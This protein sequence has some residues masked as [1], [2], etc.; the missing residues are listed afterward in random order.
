M[1]VRTKLGCLRKTERINHNM[2]RQEF[3]C[4]SLNLDLPDEG[5]RD[6][7]SACPVCGSPLGLRLA[8]VP[9]AQV[10]LATVLLL[11][12]LLPLAVG[13][14]FTFFSV[15]AADYV[16]KNK[17]VEARSR[18]ELPEYGPDSV[19]TTRTF[20]YVAFGIAGLLAVGAAGATATPAGVL[21][22]M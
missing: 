22:S 10:G 12:A 11:F 1:R 14:M 6:E 15:S 5:K 20:S 9:S 17:H 8:S 13:G 21:A 16:A 2:L 3:A 7:E 4:W 19:G 18:G